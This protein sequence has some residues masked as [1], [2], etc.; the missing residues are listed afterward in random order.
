MYSH[1]PVKYR[2]PFCQV[3]RRVENRDDYSRV[4]DIVYQDERVMAWVALHQYPRNT[5]NMLVVPSAHY[6]NVFDLP[7]EL[8]ADLYRAA[9][10]IAFALKRAYAYAC[11]GISTRQH[12]KPAGSQDVWHYHLRVTPRFKNDGFYRNF[13][14]KFLMTAEERAAHAARLNIFWNRED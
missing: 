1:A 3:A 2:C 4:S 8:G 5:P 10:R 13:Y 11:D 7:P 12:N 14:L 6:E 9:Q